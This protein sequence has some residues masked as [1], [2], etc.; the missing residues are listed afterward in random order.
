MTYALDRVSHGREAVERR[1]ERI[2]FVTFV[3]NAQQYC[4][5]IM[6]VREIRMLQGITSLP[7]APDYVRGVI[8][9]RG[10]IVPVCDPKLRFGIGETS[11]APGSAVV[12]VSVEGRLNG[13]LVDEVLDI[14]SVTRSEIAP[15][16]DADNSRR[17]PFFQGLITLND[18]L[19]I[20]IDLGRLIAEAES[21]L[22]LDA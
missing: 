22:P 13:L 20:V 16:P 19:L 11:I 4:I 14:V 2:Q 8:N 3:L 6:S 18:D 10:T 9:L 21:E 1:E 15:V 17:N 7:G 12:V 5:D